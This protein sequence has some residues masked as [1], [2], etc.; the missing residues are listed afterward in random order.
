[1]ATVC[2]PVC[3]RHPDELPGALDAAAAVADLVEVRA[4]CLT[5]V[6]SMQL[7]RLFNAIK[8]PLIV[9][10]RSSEE[11]GRNPHDLESRRRFWKDLSGLAAENFIDLE[12]DLV[13]EFSGADAGTLPVEWR[14]VICSH[15]DF[16]RV[17]DNLDQIFDRMAATPA[18]V[19]K[20]A[21]T[22]RDAIDCLPVFGLLDR[23]QRDGRQLLAIAMGQAGLMTR[24]LGPARG[25]FLTYG[26]ISEGRGTAPGQVTMA[27]LQEL[28]RIDR[29]DR[30]TRI[31][32][33]IGQPVGHSLSPHIH[34]ASFAALGLNAVFIPFEVGDAVSF[35][36]R[37]VHPAKRELD[38][39]LGGLSVTAPHKSTVIAELDWIDPACLEI[40]AVN[41]IVVR[42]QELHGY[43]TD[44]AGFIAP[45]RR[46]LGPLKDARCAVVGAG[47]AAR[48]CVWALKQEDA[49]TAIFAR[50]Q[51]QAE[52]LAQTFKVRAESFPAASFN[53][54]DIVINA[55]PLGTHGSRADESIANAQ[56]L[57]G[58]RLAYDL[59]YNPS[60]TKFLREARAAGCKV[61]DGMEM[62]LEQGIEQFKLW[63]GTQPDIEVM[64]SMAARKLRS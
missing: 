28:Y 53:G 7:L 36:R 63:T 26:S 46:A 1:M 59:V 56:Q 14:R 25:A 24:I 64:R 41:T 3:V 48:A 39:R 20:I 32:G 29:I 44:A 42:D 19:I 34:N 51:G 8:R 11:G 18:G 47:G 17:P 33:I 27:E 16:D 12:L 54:F 23:A 38:W 50:D 10:L 2:V 6:D 15:H 13:D 60:E 40:G 43:N 49:S 55:T 22:A 9:T 45:L 52:F 58:V 4:D 61:L 30:E 31:F 57:A 35:M 5:I 21:V 62:L 37:M